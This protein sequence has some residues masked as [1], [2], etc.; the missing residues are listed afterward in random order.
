MA[1]KGGFL[2]KPVSTNTQNIANLLVQG[3]QAIEDRKLKIGEIAS[4]LVKETNKT[5][6]EIP[7]TGPADHPVLVQ[8]TSN[9][10]RNYLADAYKRFTDGEISLSELKTINSKAYSQ[11]TM[12]SKSQELAAKQNEDLKKGIA[13]G[14]YSG[15]A[16]SMNYGIYRTS[17]TGDNNESALDVF[18]DDFGDIQLTQ[19]ILVPTLDG[20]EK[21][22]VP[23]SKT[24]NLTQRLSPANGFVP[25]LA[26]DIE[27]DVKTFVGNIKSSGLVTAELIDEKD[28]NNKLTGNKI[29]IVKVSPGQ[30]KN[31]R[32]GI[33]SAVISYQ[34]ED[35]FDIAHKFGM[36]T[37]MDRTYKPYT[38]ERINSRF[39]NL[40]I[41]ANGNAISISPE[42]MLIKTSDDGLSLDLT[43]K[44]V[45]ILEGFI[46][47]KLYTAID[48]ELK[49]FR[50]KPTEEKTVAD[51]QQID[52]TPSTIKTN[53]DLLRIAREEQSEFNKLK[54]QGIILGKTDNEGN[55]LYP[56]IQSQLS[57]LL[58]ATS[59]EGA[60][61]AVVGLNI[62]SD[63]SKKF[64]KGKFISSTGQEIKSVTNILSVKRGNALEFVVLG[65]SDIADISLQ[66][67]AGTE[68]KVGQTVRVPEGISAPLSDTQVANLYV[69]LWDN[70]ET[71][72]ELAKKRGYD[73]KSRHT[74]DKERNLQYRKALSFIISDYAE[75]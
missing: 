45:D 1:F 68:V 8:K 71:F 11:A 50:D 14:K 56:Q 34:P 72:R 18:V 75:Q 46:R 39:T 54:N 10:L 73:R 44:Q 60:K 58:N 70:N 40:S 23:V 19:S 7:V 6:A 5:I 24:A 38:Q 21:R 65:P 64:L 42:D 15:I 35:F 74:D 63:F 55:P 67:M 4:D 29:S 20:L 9:A 27:N 30:D 51:I 33:E 69:D 61:N 52:F 12:F 57:A 17:S 62:P 49:I 43:P 3:T 28:E 13:E 59:G 32:E 26:V 41:D 48:P 47:K 66:S 31:V 53:L 22:S 37:D 2:I 36:K 25:P 16:N